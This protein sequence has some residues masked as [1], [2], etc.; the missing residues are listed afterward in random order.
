MRKSNVP[1]PL[2]VLGAGVIGLVGNRRWPEIFGQTAPQGNATP[3]ALQ[4]RR[5]HALP[6]RRRA[7]RIALVAAISVT[8][9][10]LATVALV[11]GN[12]AKVLI[13]AFVWLPYLILSDRVNITY[14]Q[15]VRFDDR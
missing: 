7:L 1:F 3:A 10:G 4:D 11:H 5:S 15:R 2:I 13:S 8:L 9:L 12:I 6:S 14:R